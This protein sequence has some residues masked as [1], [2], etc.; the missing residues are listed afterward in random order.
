MKTRHVYLALS[1]L[2][3]LVPNAAFA[4]WI[5]EHGFSPRLFLNDLFANGVSGFFAL[6]VVIS[7][8]VVCAFATIEGRRLGLR[9]WWLAIAAVMLFGVSLALPL[10]LYQRQLHL[11]A[12]TV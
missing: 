12:A 11:D 9:R 5:L 8:V 1:V 7:A 6:D 2:G 3:L 4:S 10:F